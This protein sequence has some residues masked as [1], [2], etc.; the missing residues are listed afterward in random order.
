MAISHFSQIEHELFWRYIKCF[1]VFLTKYGIADKWEIL[2]I[3]DMGLNSKTHALLEHWS[4][5]HK[6]VN[7]ASYLL[8]EL[9]GIHLNFEKAR[10]CYAPFWRDLCNFSNCEANSCP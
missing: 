1:N 9:A 4:F 7:K 8:S 2:D 10:S 3:V 6:S 5:H